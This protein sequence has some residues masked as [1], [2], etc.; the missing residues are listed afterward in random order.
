MVMAMSNVL[1]VMPIAL[2]A[3]VA[4]MLG[5][6]D[7]PAGPDHHPGPEVGVGDLCP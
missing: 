5:G 2:G 7:Q 4:T 6:M 3:F 1:I